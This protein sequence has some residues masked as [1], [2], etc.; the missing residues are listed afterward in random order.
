MRLTWLPVAL[1]LS[2]GICGGQAYPALPRLNVDIAE[3]SVSGLSSGAFMAVQFDVAHASIVKGAGV[4]AGGPYY[5]AQN[6]ALR[7][8]TR[9]SCTLDPAHAVCGVSATSTDV[10][11]LERATR[12]A[13]A[14]GEIDDPSHLAAHRV[15]ILAGSGDPIVPSVVAPQLAAYYGAFQ[16]TG[17]NVTVK[18]NTGH[19][20]PTVAFGN[21]C[22]TTA[23]PYIGRCGFDAAKEIFSWIYGTLKPKRSGALTGRYTQFDQSRYVQSASFLWRTGMD[24]TGWIYVPRACRQGERCRLHVALHGCEQGQNY[25]PLHAPPG[26]G[27]YY[28]TTF[29]RHAGYAPWADTN[30][31]VVLFPQAVSIPYLNPN[32]CWDWWGYTD[33]NYANR[34]GVQIAAIRAMVDRIA[35]GFH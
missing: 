33:G 26:G 30:H 19:T 4:V 8:T 5:C 18:P 16:T 15:Y 21:A 25:L 11:A 1:L 29:V 6:E 10:A 17:I 7:A 12:A 2:P 31:I 24:T 14:A 23:S 3:T 9:C 34:Q 13:F 27:L 35:S 32:G 28:G 22:A 20:M